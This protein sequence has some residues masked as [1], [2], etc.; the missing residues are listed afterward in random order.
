M[1][2]DMIKADLAFTPFKAS[3]INTKNVLFQRKKYNAQLGF[4]ENEKKRR[5]KSI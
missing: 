4:D 1:Q 2:T 5:G 3:Q